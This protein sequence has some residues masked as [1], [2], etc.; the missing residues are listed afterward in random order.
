MV[1]ATAETKT[2]TKEK[3]QSPNAMTG[4]RKE[5]HSSTTDTKSKRRER[6]K[7]GECFKNRK[8]QKQRRPKGKRRT[9]RKT[10]LNTAK[11]GRPDQ[12]PK[13]AEQEK[14][15]VQGASKVSKAPLSLLPQRQHT[16]INKPIPTR[17]SEMKL[18]QVALSAEQILLDR[19]GDFGYHLH[20]TSG[21]FVGDIRDVESSKGIG[22]RS[23][24]R[25]VGGVE[26]MQQRSL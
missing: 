17:L 22:K 3:L 13:E 7:R 1:G 14:Q 16:P 25:R 2:E 9:K 4:K 19:L 5:L 18:A 6:S 26:D 20:D 10:K 15:E 24:E 23:F 12:K 11:E 8:R 21:C